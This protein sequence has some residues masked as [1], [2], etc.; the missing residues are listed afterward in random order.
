MKKL[1]N[2]RWRPRSGC[3]GRIMKKTFLITIIQANLCC[4]FTNSPELL[5]LK[6]LPLSDHH[7]HFWAAIFDFTTVSCCFFL[8]GPHLFLQFGCFC[9]VPTSFCNLTNLCFFAGAWL[10]CLLDDLT[11]DELYTGRTCCGLA[12]YYRTI[13]Y[14]LVACVRTLLLWEYFSWRV[15]VLL[16]YLDCAFLVAFCFIT[17]WSLIIFF[18]PLVKAVFYG[19]STF[20][21]SLKSFFHVVCVI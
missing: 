1:W 2:Q 18:F 20:P 21:A 12:V 3:G 13:D 8:H 17:C 10:N 16:E 6:I 9:V 14:S 4:W 5:L 11:P 19:H 15:T 7:S